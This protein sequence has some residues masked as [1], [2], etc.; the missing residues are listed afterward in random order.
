[1]RKYIVLSILLVFAVVANAVPAQRVWK[2]YV[3]SD[4]SQLR[5]MMQGDENLHYYK[6]TD[7]LVAMRNDLGQF[8]Y[9]QVR[10]Q[11]LHETDMLVHDKEMRSTEEQAFVNTLGDVATECRRLSATANTFPKKIGEPTGVFEGEKR[12][13]V[14]MVSFNDLDFTIT[15]DQLEEMLNQTGYTNSFGAIGSVHD[16]FLSQSYNRFSLVFDVVGPIKLPKNSSYYGYNSQGHDSYNR[17][18]E[19]VKESIR[20][21][22]DEADLTKYDWDGNGYVDQVFLYY[23]GYGEATGGDASTIWPHESQVY[24]ALSYD[25]VKM[26]TYACSNELNGSE[27]D[28]MMGI[29]TFCHEFTHCLGIPDFYDTSDETDNYGM[30]I[31]DPMCQG[32]Y[33]GDSWIPAPYTGYERHF[34]GWKNYRLLSEP[35]RV[36]KLECIEN[37]GETYQIVNPGNAD[38]YYLLENRNG[39]YG[40]DRGLYTNSGGQR[41]SGLLVTHVTYVKNR[42]TYNTVNA[43][44]E[45]QCMTI[46]HADNSDATTMEYMG[47]TYLDVNE[48]FGDLYPHRVSLTE[49]HNSLSDT[50]TPQDV[51]NTPNTDGSYLMHTSVTSITKQ[52]RYVNFTF[53]NGTLP[54]SDPDGIQEVTAQGQA[55][56]GVYNLSGVRVSQE[57]DDV[58]LPHGIYIVRDQEGRSTKVRK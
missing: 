56:A 37:G 25:G 9:A 13:L 47:Q 8:V 11:Q 29:G 14:V 19:F 21:A 49:N 23:A 54:W 46:F 34:C 55:A 50:S 24:P 26:Q 52:S 16:Y 44:N 20:L 43:G 17:V 57:K 2:S 33:N 35:C 1:M 39:S 7:G 27:G 22:A 51:L 40:W 53:M 58:S 10:N 41:I 28:T 42:W 45:Y 31:F 6:T 48:Y 15:K 30:G 38:E 36:S 5:L 3:Q 12:G 18:A 4:G 32:S